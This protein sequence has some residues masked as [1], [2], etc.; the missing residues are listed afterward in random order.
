MTGTKRPKRLIVALLCGVL[1]L[2]CPAAGA[3]P[4][5]PELRE[6]IVALGPWPPPLR[7]DPSNRVSGNPRAIEL[8][9]L[10]FREARISSVGYIACVACHRPDH[11]FADGRPRAHGMADVPRNAPALANLR[12]QRW[13]GWGGISDSLWL[14]SIRPILDAR[15]L[16]GSPELVAKL[17]VRDPDLAAC[18]AQVFGVSPRGAPQ[19]TLVNVG[20]AL[21]AYVETL[22]TERTPFD[23]YRDALAR[24]DASAAAAYP[25]AARRGL[26]I[27]AGAGGCAGCH[28]G[29]NFS[30]GLFHRGAESR[31]G[32][33]R[34]PDTGRLDDARA[35]L[36]HPLNLLGPANDDRRHRGSAEATRAVRVG[37]QLEG[38]FR[39]PSLRNVAV[40]APYLHDGRA[41]TLREAVQHAGGKALKPA[42]IDDL[43]AFLQTLTDR[44]GQRRPW[45]P[46]VMESHCSQ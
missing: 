15:E 13:Y 34:T 32:L 20:K 28:A 14:A 9:R 4:I 11:A 38:L 21:A 23:D 16:G 5:T 40:T 33:G 31:P 27:F 41:D 29:P 1:V 26:A 22:V 10:L 35:L 8:G 7:P 18:Y 24:N 3:Q 19:R 43:V 30:D 46:S 44:H 39:T 17:F 2:A 6:R 25:A 37:A 45:Q 42:Q 12:W 36:A